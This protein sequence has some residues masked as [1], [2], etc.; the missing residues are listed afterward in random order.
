MIDRVPEKDCCICG[1]CACVCPKQAISFTHVSDSFGYP[2]I[3]MEACVGCDLCE[4][5]CPI[6]NPCK[7]EC[8]LGYPVAF[9][10]RSKDV[11]VRISST[12]GAIFFEA[13]KYIISNGGYV[14]GTVFDDG[15]KVKHILTNS[16]VDLQRMRGSKYAQSDIG[17]TYVEIKNS[18]EDGKCVLFCGCPCQV[19]ALINFLGEKY[20]N[21]YLM[22]FVCHGIPSQTMLNEYFA[23]LEKRKN[24]KIV[25]F[26]FRDKCRGWH[27]SSVVAEY[28]NGKKYSAPI[29]VDPYMKAFLS[30]TTMKE[31]CY[32]CRFKGLVSGSDLTLGD[33]WG[34][35]VLLPDWDDNTG[36]SAVIANTGKG[37]QLLEL[38]DVQKQKTEMAQVIKYNQNIVKSTHENEIRGQ[39]FAYALSHGYGRAMLHFFEETR[40]QKRKRVTRYWAKCI[41]YKLSGRKKPLY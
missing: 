16:I 12:S 8:D 31:S 39:F 19:S 6:L 10:A 5:V 27:Y 41:Y 33:F 13:G 2:E 17:N 7:N 18:L 34:A 4:T 9:A 1:A 32:H 37:E 35:E 38:I 22:D 11:D 28:E 24:A 3:N 26:R 30:G 29:T 36:I 25:D 23:E 15:F 20:E 40:F 21:L 14:C